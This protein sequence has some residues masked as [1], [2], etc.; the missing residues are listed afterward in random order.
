MRDVQPEALYYPKQILAPDLIQSALCLAP[1]PDDEVLGCGGLLCRMAEAGSTV[2]VAIFTRGE[3]ARDDSGPDDD[4]LQDLTVRRMQESR[5]AAAVLGLSDPVFLDWPDRGVRY[6]EPLIAAIQQMLDGQ[7]P[8]AL[9]LPSLSEPHPDHQAIALAGLAAARRSQYPQTLLFYEVGAPLYSN[10]LL[11]LGSTAERKWRAI[12]EFASQLDIQPYEAHAQA[13]SRMRAFGLGSGCDA[14]E[15]YFQVSAETVRREGAA[16]AVPVWPMARTEQLLA[17]APEQLPLVSVLIRSIDRPHLEDAVA[18]VAAQT[19]P[20]LEII[21][22]NASGR[23]HSP[24]CYPPRRLTL[25]MV[26]PEPGEANCREDVWGGRETKPTGLT[27]RSG[28]ANLALGSARGEL[29]L[30]L[31]DDDLIEPGHIQKLVDALAERATAVAAYTGV[32]VEGPEGSHLRD[33]DLPWSAERLNGINFLPIHSVLFRLDVVRKGEVEFN[34]AL[35]VLEDWDFWRNL[36]SKGE[37]VHCPGVSA[38]YRQGRGGSGIGDP[39]HPNHWRLWHRKIVEK[40]LEARNSVDVAATL[41]WHAIE[42]DTVQAQHESLN[43]R[44]ANLQATLDLQVRQH[45]ETLESLSKAIQELTE[46]NQAVAKA[47]WDLAVGQQALDQAKVDLDYANAV[48]LAKE[49]LCE[50]LR[51]QHAQAQK[52]LKEQHDA[53]SAQNAREWKAQKEQHEADRAQLQAEIQMMLRSRS[54]RVTRPLRFLTNWLRGAR[55]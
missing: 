52:V 38:V 20:N 54:W 42:L 31:D 19:Y 40:D 8:Q 17:N 21:L 7:K 53:D 43:A 5:N 29:A 55:T 37:F 24:V 30:F 49:D 23:K 32:R 45:A 50:Q 44:H 4:S 13:L 1:H 35:P 36:A 22:V 14:A 6:G 33:Y 46:K 28:A 39:L 11:D 9:I 15:A 47:A 41:V 16:A 26:E 25:R 10:T 3:R 12:R 27:N 48:I 51:I 34:P 2:N 18:S